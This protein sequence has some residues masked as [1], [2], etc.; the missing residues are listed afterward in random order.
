MRADL[1]AVIARASEACAR[2]TL[3]FD[4]TRIEANLGALRDAARAVGITALF[5]AKS[6]P[7]PR[8]RAL[9]GALLDGFDAA[10]AGELAEL[11]GTGVLSVVDPSGRATEAARG[12]RG[13]RL[14]VGCETLEQVRAAPAHAEIAIRLSASLTGRD[15]AIGAVLDG[16]GHRRSRFGLDVGRAQRR[17]AVRAMVAAAGGR[18]VGLHVHHGP[19]TATTGERFIA[20]ARAVLATADDAELTPRFVDLGGA[21]HGVAELPAALA[22]VRAAVPA[23]IE[24]IIEPGRLRHR[25]RRVRLRA[26]RGGARARRPAAAGP[27]PVADLSPALEPDRAGR[28]RTAARAGPQRAR[29]RPDLLRGGRAR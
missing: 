2:P 3:A 29:G 24:V 28:D 23:A 19:V 15:P 5:A 1:P 21:W 20:T 13:R 12:W 17:A 22:E 4:A 10:S 26:G 8:V 6:F 18:P 7:H 9:A 11:P 16:T 25:G 27:R 14:I